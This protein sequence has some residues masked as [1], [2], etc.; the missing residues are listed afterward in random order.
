MFVLMLLY[1]VMT[2]VRPQDYMPA[3]TGIPV[4]PVV[5][6]LAAVI[7]LASSKKHLAEPQ[8]LLLP[9]FL[10]AMVA[11]L[12]MTGWVGGGL[13]V[14]ERFGPFVIA[15]VLLANSI[16]NTR[17][18][19]WVFATFAVCTAILA[20]HGVVQARTG[21]GWTGVTMSEDFRIQYIGIFNDP[22]D[23]GLLFVMVLPMVLYLMGRGGLG[24]LMRVLWFGSALLLLYGVYLTHSRGAMVALLAMMGAYVWRKRGWVTAAVIGVVALAALQVVAPRMD[25]LSAGESSAYGRV[26]A[27]FVGLHLFLEHPLFGV[28][29]GLFG[30]YNRLTAHNSFVLALAETGIVG[31]TIWLTFIGY[32][33]WMM[34][35]VLQHEPEIAEDNSIAQAE[36]QR[37]RTLAMTLLMAQAGFFAAAFFL[38]RT[39]VVI[40][41]LMEAV[42]VGYYFVA[43]EA[44][45]GLPQFRLRDRLLLWPAVSVA[46]IAGLFVVVRVLLATS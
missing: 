6:I 11:S 20:I 31:Y 34:F 3:F 21:I 37:H 15:F 16:T 29:A 25:E 14:L 23:L 35:S 24:G 39:Y 26:D 10:M 9:A 27:W 13:V 5:M 28:G 42:V 1:L 4:M 43:R 45:P 30:E 17:R 22:N 33:V 18:V 44:Y 38:S 36:W 46:S 32:G 7:W 8:Y 40:L 19:T 12:I 2:I 41:Y